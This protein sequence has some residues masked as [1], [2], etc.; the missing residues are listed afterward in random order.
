MFIVYLKLL[1]VLV[2]LEELQ[3]DVVKYVQ[4][5]VRRHEGKDH[6]HLHPVVEVEAVEHQF[7]E[8]YKERQSFRGGI[9]WIFYFIYVIKQKFFALDLL[10]AFKQIICYLLIPLLSHRFSASVKWKLHPCKISWK[11]K[12]KNISPYFI[13][14]IQ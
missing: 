11:F 7:L 5:V 1:S 2:I 8:S 13:K 14:Q 12:F 10:T 6:S 9:V 3:K 4:H